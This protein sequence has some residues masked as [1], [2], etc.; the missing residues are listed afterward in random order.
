M[1]QFKLYGYL[2]LIFCSLSSYA[3]TV[4]G[5]SFSHHDWE[6]ACDNTR[7][8]RAVGYQSD[9]GG[10][11]LPL[12]LLLERAAGANQQ[13]TAQLM[14]GD[15]SEEN[16]NPPDVL[17]MNVNNKFLG[18]VKVD[19]GKLSSK[20]TAALLTALRRDSL[21]EW[22][23][24]KDTWVLSDKG[25]SAVLLKMD[26]FQGR[27]GTKGALIKKGNLDESKVLPPL[28]TPIIISPKLPK[29]LDADKAF[30]IKNEKA[31][32]HAIEKTINNDDDNCEGMYDYDKGDFEKQEI[33]ITRLNQ[34]RFL[35][36]TFCWRAAYNEGYGYWIIND[37]P[38]YAP[39]LITTI[40]EEGFD[41]AISSSLKGRG[42]GDCWSTDTWTW[43][44]KDFIHSASST[45]GM[46][47]MVAAG[48]AWQL[49]TIVTEVRV[50][51]P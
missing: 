44:G 24:A 16:I 40:A 3:D 34:N 2:S 7:T 30:L 45:T 6:I 37:K 5:I 32:R 43:N 10:E 1:Q 4:K 36:S 50:V 38:P 42:I 33:K 29:T 26:E 13:V 27:L 49:P 21:I 41:G 18:S 8:C 22:L 17:M 20:Q 31:I 48:G 14:L 25:A 12:A 9:E 47:K 51:K 19:T 46:C 28:P 39:K 11:N 23:S 15:R 35:V